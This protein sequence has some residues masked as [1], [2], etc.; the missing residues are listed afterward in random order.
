MGDSSPTKVHVES[1]RNAQGGRSNHGLSNGCTLD[2]Y[3]LQAKLSLPGGRTL[4]AA[5]CVHIS[6]DK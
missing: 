5:P 2:T 3:W 1:D 6:S 4:I